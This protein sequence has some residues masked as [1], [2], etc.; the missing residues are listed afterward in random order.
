MKNAIG[1]PHGYLPSAD[2]NNRAFFKH[3]WPTAPLV[4]IRPGSVVFTKGDTI[5][6][7][8]ATALQT[9]QA[10]IQATFN[11]GQDQKGSIFD[12]TNLYGVSPSDAS[13]IN[14]AIQ[15]KTGGT[16]LGLNGDKTS[17]V[18]PI[19]YFE[20]QP[21]LN[22]YNS[23]LATLA[24]RLW[25]RMMVGA[26]GTSTPL[27]SSI[28]WVEQIFGSGNMSSPST[29][30]TSYGGF[31]SFWADN[32]S[33]VS[34]TASNEVGESKVAAVVKAA[35]AMAHE[36][37]FA[38]GDSLFSS[39]AGTISGAVDTIGGLFGANATPTSSGLTA[40]LGDAILG[41]NPMFP[42]IWKE[43]AFSRSYDLSFKFHSPY[44][45]PGAIFQNVLMPFT[46]LLALVLPILHS[47][48]TYSQPFVFQLDCPGHFSCDLGI[49]TSFSFTRGGSDRLWTASGLPREID[50]TMQV[51]DLYPVLASSH[52]NKSLYCNIGMGTFLDNLASINLAASGQNID[53]MSQLRAKAL[54]ALYGIDQI[55]NTVAAGL[56]NWF[57]ENFGV[58]NLFGN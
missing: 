9:D 40:S 5:A 45:D 33:S 55:P 48:A 38:I 37:H 29:M 36:V 8:L 3:M 56:T 57:Q 22:R 16:V 34:E 51:K 31:W 42:E 18:L 53:F 35:A 25:S 50:V 12:L 27:G 14:L 7:I 20:F 52:N 58:S 11:V 28:N 46:Q 44:G 17:T 54:S 15:Q 43:S 10:A 41:V 1:R 47:T 32:A 26:P 6:G 4:L 30:S 13:A 24:A 23:V 21:E 49:C 2:P 39:V 19:R